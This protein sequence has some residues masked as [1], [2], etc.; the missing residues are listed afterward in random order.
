MRVLAATENHGSHIQPLDY[1]QARTH[2]GRR[3]PIYSGDGLEYTHWSTAI[4]IALSSLHHILY[5][6][7]VLYT[8]QVNECDNS[9]LKA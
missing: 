7:K 9:A 8:H 3:V 2:G 4:G 1:M 5:D 6:C